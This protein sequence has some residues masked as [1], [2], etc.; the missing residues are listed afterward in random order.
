MFVMSILAT[1]TLIFGQTA[2]VDQQ[3]DKTIMYM[4]EE[5]KVAKDVYDFFEEKYGNQIFANI[6]SA[7]EMHQ[8]M[9]EKLAINNDLIKA[10]EFNADEAGIYA[11]Q[12][13]QELYNSLIADGEKSFTDALRVGV[14]IEELNIRDLEASIE[15]SEDEASVTVYNYLKDASERHLNAFTKNL[16]MN[17]VNYDSQLGRQM[18]G[19][20][21]KGSQMKGNQM[22]GN[23]LKGNQM[24]G[25]NARDCSKGEKACC[26][27][28]D[29][30]E[31]CAGKGAKG[32]CKSR[33]SLN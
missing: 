25:N 8:E 17:G 11:N 24:K 26:S 2:S 29:K 3:S 4:L 1:G 12:E 7:E 18:K 23:Q 19:N 13:L 6:S 32:N 14:E 22:K 28:K 21:M 16:E 31:K 10:G 20:Q 9:M 5:E 30:N 33:K 27:N 15:G